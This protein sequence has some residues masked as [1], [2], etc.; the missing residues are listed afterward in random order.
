MAKKTKPRELKPYKH[1]PFK[2]QD[3]MTSKVLA[4]IDDEGIKPSALSRE[5]GI[6]GSTFGNWR[7]RKTKRPQFAT[8]QATL[9]AV[10]KQLVISNIK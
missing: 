8:F 3:P 2:G 10:G 9:M 6:S 4:A 5:T 1:Y 7:K